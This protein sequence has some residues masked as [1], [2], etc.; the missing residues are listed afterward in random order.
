MALPYIK[1]PLSFEDGFLDRTGKSESIVDYVTLIL[2]TK[3]GTLKD[4]P[5]FGNALWEKDINLGDMRFS[6][7]AVS[8]VEK[9]VSRNEPRVSNIQ[10]EF[11][12]EGEVEKAIIVKAK[13]NEDGEKQDIV[14]EFDFFRY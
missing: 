11:R 8:V 10:V 5:D 1:L 13:Y 12:R 4:I 7:D 14:I 9:S 6:R 3:R 2:S